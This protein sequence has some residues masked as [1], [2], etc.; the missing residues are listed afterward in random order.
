MPCSQRV[1]EATVE[2]S[3]GPSGS[4]IGTPAVLLQLLVGFSTGENILGCPIPP[5]PFCH[6]VPETP[7]QATGVSLQ[8]PGPVTKETSC[9]TCFL[10][11][12]QT[13]GLVPSKVLGMTGL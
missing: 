6:L 11:S 4:T 13:G 8:I 2:H 3:R 9:G 1:E 12:Q 5:A 7:P 10:F